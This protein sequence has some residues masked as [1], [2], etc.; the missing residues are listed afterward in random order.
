[1]GRKIATQLPSLKS[2][3]YPKWPKFSMVRNQQN[4]HQQNYTNQYNHRK[5]VR[6]LC[7]LKPND[8]VLIKIPGQKSWSTQARVINQADTPRSY[9]VQTKDGAIL[10]CNRQHLQLLNH[11]PQEELEK[12]DYSNPTPIFTRDKDSEA[13]PIRQLIDN[14]NQDHMPNDDTRT[15]NNNQDPV[16]RSFRVRNPQQRLIENSQCKTVCY[17]KRYGLF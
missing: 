7:P 5:G 1:M 11:I 6:G 14:P 12:I 10:Q 16:R 15:L 8:Y 17:G 4:K 9:I 2:N 3:M 13:M